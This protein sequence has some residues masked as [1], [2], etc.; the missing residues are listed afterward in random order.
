MN[1]RSF[2]QTAGSAAISTAASPRQP[3]VVFVLVDQWR[4]QAFGYTRDPNAHTPA[5]DSLASESVNFGHAVSGFPVCSPYRAS[6]MTGQYAVKHGVVVNDVPMK[7][8]G[9]TLGETFQK[10]GYETGYI[11][12]WHIFGSPDGKCGRRLAFIPK[13]SRFGFDYWK[14]CECSH[15]YNRSLYYQADDPAERYWEGYDAIGQ[16]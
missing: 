14:A 16:T 5:I 2:L 7:P 6:L 9:P 15:N 12:K 13:E 10:A 8:N 1:R 3:N 4:A 11:G